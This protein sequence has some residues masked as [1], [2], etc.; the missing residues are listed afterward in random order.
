MSTGTVHANIESKICHIKVA[1]SFQSLNELIFQARGVN[2]ILKSA[3]EI[4][5][6]DVRKK[7]EKKAT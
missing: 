1:C 2:E 6:V 7:R 5:I 4:Q 3:L